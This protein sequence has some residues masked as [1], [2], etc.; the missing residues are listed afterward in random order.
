MGHGSRGG[1]CCRKRGKP[2]ISARTSSLLHSQNPPSN[3]RSSS[4]VSRSEEKMV[5]GAS[6]TVSPCAGWRLRRRGFMAAIP[7]LE[8]ELELTSNGDPWC[9]PPRSRCGEA[10]GA[11]A[12]PDEATSFVFEPCCPCAG[13]GEFWRLGSFLQ[14]EQ[15]VWGY[16]LLNDA[17]AVLFA[18]SRVCGVCRL[19]PTTPRIVKYAL[20]L[21]KSYYRKVRNPGKSAPTRLLRSCFRVL[22]SDQSRQ[23]PHAPVR[24]RASSAFHSLQAPARGACPR[25]GRLSLE[26]LG[27]VRLPAIWQETNCEL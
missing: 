10:T 21:I 5:V 6:E 25:T 9:V 1:R 3:S 7:C 15:P 8:N 26:E 16:R 19:S 4:G 20:R 13:C 17:I 2:R 18:I 23:A 22:R 24:S 12:G 27:P 14:T 11:I